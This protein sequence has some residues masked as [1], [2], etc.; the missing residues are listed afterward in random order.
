MSLNK[1][2]VSIFLFIAKNGQARTGTKQELAARCADGKQFGRISNC[3]KCGGG[4]LR[5]NRD[6]GTYTCPG[7]MEDTDFINC[8]A[9]LNFDEVKRLEWNE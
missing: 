2:Q 4:K 3:H 6:K 1:F 5:F 9:H 8:G 7:Y